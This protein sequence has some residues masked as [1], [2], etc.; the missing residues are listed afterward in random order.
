MPDDGDALTEQERAILE[1]EHQWWR[2]PGAKESAIF[3]QFGMSFVR[4]AQV[5]N[6]LIDR[7]AAMAADPR[8]VRRLR[9]IRDTKR[10]RRSPARR[11]AG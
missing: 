5:L 2:Y 1:F 10:A 6:Q 7:P 11:L 3:E 9:A 4:Y 8:V